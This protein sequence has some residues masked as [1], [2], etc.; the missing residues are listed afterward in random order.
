[1]LIKVNEPIDFD[2]FPTVLKTEDSQ[3]K[4]NWNME[5]AAT[6]SFT[7]SQH[8]VYPLEFCYL[9]LYLPIVK[10]S[11]NSDFIPLC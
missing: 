4:S 1:M 3:K 8:P 7:I 10:E 9:R 2:F 11:V 6:F 5:N